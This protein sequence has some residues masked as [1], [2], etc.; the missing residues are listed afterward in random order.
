MRHYGSVVYLHSDHLGSLSVATD[1]SG[2]KR[3]EQ[4]YQPFGALR[5]G[6]TGQSLTDKLYTG[7]TLDASTGLYYYGARYYDP[8][9]GR[10]VQPDTIVPQPGNP[11]ALNRFSYGYNNPLRF[12]DPTGHCGAAAI[13]LERD[14]V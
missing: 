14:F 9:L 10:F 11:Q 6:G 13:T 7:Q 5:S 3:N 12:T 8:A 2:A 1:S 4:R